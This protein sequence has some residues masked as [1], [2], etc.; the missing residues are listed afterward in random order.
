[1]EEAVMNF[2]DVIPF[3]KDK[4]CMVTGGGGSIG[5]ELVRRL[6]ELDAKKIIIVD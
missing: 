6:A 5:S 3:V 4:I 2:N 1:M